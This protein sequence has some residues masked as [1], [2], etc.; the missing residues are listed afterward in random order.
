MRSISQSWLYVIKIWA[1]FF[2]NAERCLGCKLYVWGVNYDVYFSSHVTDRVVVG[3]CPGTYPPG[4]GFLGEKL[5]FYPKLYIFFMF[6]IF[7]ES[8]TYSCSISVTS[9]KILIKN[10]NLLFIVFVP[11]KVLYKTNKH[12]T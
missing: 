5:G 8:Y 2:E 3:S 12:L 1:T 10:I 11:I 6:A 7:F 9:E 4:L